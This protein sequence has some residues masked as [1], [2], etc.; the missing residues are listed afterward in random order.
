MALMGAEVVFKRGNCI[1]KKNGT[2][3]VIGD[4]VD[5][6]LHKMN[7]IP[8]YANVSIEPCKPSEEIWLCRFGHV[9]YNYI[10]QMKRKE[11]VHGMDLETNNNIPDKHCEACIL[12]KMQKKPLPKQSS[13]RATKP[14]Q[15]VHSDVCG[16]M[17]VMSKGGSRYMLT[18]TDDYSRFVNT[19]FIKTKGEVLTKFKEYVNYIQKQF[20]HKIKSLVL[21]KEEQIGDPVKVLRSD[22]GG[23]YKSNEYTEFCKEKGIAREYKNSYCPEQN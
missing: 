14:F 10:D 19:Y 11:M 9:N 4:L 22:N 21:P 1:V 18:F 15:I 8:E 3:Y 5:S 13:H 6:K 12:G 2:E 16:P 20:G 7:A 17:Q 23:E